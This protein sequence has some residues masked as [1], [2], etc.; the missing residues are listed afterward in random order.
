MKTKQ[1]VDFFCQ[2]PLIGDFRN[3]WL[4]NDYTQFIESPG[5]TWGAGGLEEQ[6]KHYPGNRFSFLQI[7]TLKINFR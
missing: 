1:V 5:I 6:F 3:P 4:K 2:I 7:C